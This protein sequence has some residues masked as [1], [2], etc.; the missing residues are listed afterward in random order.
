MADD[1]SGQS[2]LTVKIE[3]DP[4]FTVTVTGAEMQ[5]ELGR[6]F[7]Y[8]LNLTSDTR[9]GDLM[10]LLGSSA[11]LA[12]TL[13]DNS[14]RYFNG[15]IVRAAYAGMTRGSNTYHV[16]LRPWI[17]LLSQTQDNRI[18]QNQTMWNIMTSVFRT[19]GFT[20]FT[21]KRQ[22]GTGDQQLEYCVQYGET[23][24]DFVTRL[25]EKYGLYYFFTHTDGH[26][27]LALADDPNSHASIGQALPYRAQETDMRRVADHVW[28]W[29]SELHLQPGAVTF[30]DYNF[31]TPAADLTTKARQPGAH[32]YGSLEVYAYP[33]PYGETGLGQKLA[34]VRMQELA[35]R[36]EILRGISNS[37]ALA[38]GS[39]FTLSDCPD[40]AQNREYLV[41]SASY[42]F[43]LAEGQSDTRGDLIDTYRCSFAAIPGDLPFRLEPSVAWPMMRG[44][45]TAKVVGEAGQEVT[46]DQYGRIKVQFFW[47]RLNPA[48]QTASCW[49]R[50]AQSWAGAGWGSIVI[51]RIG[52]EVVVDFLDGNPDRPLVT[53][54]VY[55]ANQTVPYALP[56][57]K[58]RSTF[59]SN[60]SQGGGGANE[61]RLE[62]SK[63]SEEV[64]LQAQKDLNVV[65]L[66]GDRTATVK[67]G[68]DSTTVSQGNHS[69]T[70]STG[71]HSTTVSAGNHTL[72]VDAGSS[73]ISAGQSITLKVGANSITIDNTGVAINGVKIG[74]TAQAELQAQGGGM[75]TLQAGMIN[76]N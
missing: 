24:L 41:V 32:T 14:K 18:F 7:R 16:E 31:T 3:P 47:D 12:V 45:Q 50:V 67:L 19:A 4:G 36:R 60:S 71:N 10:S 72:S 66:Q 2:Y 39:K 64:F 28:A 49:I 35:G 33:G 74:L 8:D 23:T 59:K 20:D 56:G 5:E 26:H 1:S 21:D 25:M 75:M 34:T 62:D 40:E 6:P 42:T 38:V 57:N 11:T 53:G 68:N 51:P 27:A 54:C 30:R 17:W 15:I 63:G 55:N 48:D 76:I 73:T 37:R 13:P 29:G 46:T 61:L 69:T 44:P 22:S 58:T 70:V 43:G 52:Q 65:V 9:K